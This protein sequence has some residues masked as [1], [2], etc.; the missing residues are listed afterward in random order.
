MNVLI[1]GVCGFVGSSVARHL[2]ESSSSIRICG[3]DNLSRSGSESNRRELISLGVDVRHGDLRIASDLETIPKVDW[4]IDAA[5]LPSV[6]AG[7]DGVSSSLQLVQHNLLGTVHL[8][9][10]CKRHQVGFT[11]LSTSRVYSIASLIGLSLD[12]RSDGFVLADSNADEVSKSGISESFSTAAPVSMYGAT[13]IASETMALEYGL[14]YDFPVWINRCGVLAG[15]G[16]FGRAD[17]GIFSFWLNSHLRKR[18]LKYLGFGGSG[19]QVRDCLN[20]QDLGR[21]VSKQIE[22]GV[23]KDIPRTINVGGGEASAMS[24]KQLTKWCDDRFGPHSVASS[25]EERPFD[26]PWVVLDSSL[27]KQHWD[28]E[29]EITTAET[30]EQ[31]AQHAE[32]HPNWLELSQ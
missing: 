2:I 29:P 21:L 15:A 13:K 30:L 1:T 26:L 25:K 19:H 18:P 9:E 6:L 32:A 12:V 20:V 4:V 3:I 5:A 22:A 11:L 28:W 14:A 8:L 7:V 31:I 16:Q 17:Q 23:R 27:A 24:L 10:F